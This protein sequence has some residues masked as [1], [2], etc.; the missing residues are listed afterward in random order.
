VIIFRA[1]TDL[2]CRSL[3]R[4]RSEHPSLLLTKNILSVS[5][6]FE[7]SDAKVHERCAADGRDQEVPG[8]AAGQSGA[9]GQRG[10][11]RV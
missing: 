6:V 11:A 10:E 4:T 2:Y 3:L 8:D 9:G 5:E 1:I 7:D